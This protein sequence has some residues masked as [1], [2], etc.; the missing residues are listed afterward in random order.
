MGKRLTITDYLIAL[1]V[2]FLV[3]CMIVAFFYGVHVGKTQAEQKYEPLLKYQLQTSAFDDEQTAYHQQHLVSFYYNVYYPFRTFQ[4]SWTKTMMDIHTGQE[5]DARA[6]IK[7]MS[8]TAAEVYHSIETMTIPEKSPLLQHAQTNYLRSLRLFQEA[9][10][11]LSNYSGPTRY[12]VQ[13]FLEDPFIADAVGYALTAQ[14][15][16]YEAIVKW[17]QSIAEEELQGAD[18]LHDIKMEIAAWAELPFNIQNSV[19]AQAMLEH[20][21]FANYTPQDLT[22]VLEAMIDSGNAETLGW[23]NVQEAVKLLNDTNA[24]R[25]GDYFTYKDAYFRDEIMPQLPFY[26]EP[27]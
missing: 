26:S 1:L 9:D 14:A 13:E 22:A 17:H 15:Q 25:S 7:K 19:V 5:T 4:T 24:V 10:T 12:A 18:R 3:F 27:Q 6:A 2:V 8:S 11:R 21:I 16:F 20:R 23:H